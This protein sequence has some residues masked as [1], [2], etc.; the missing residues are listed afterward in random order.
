MMAMDVTDVL[1]ERP[2]EFLIEE[3]RFYLYPMT[4]GVSLLVGRCISTLSPDMAGFA[5]NPVAE[6]DR[7]VKERPDVA[8]RIL[9]YCTAKNREEV[10]DEESMSQR[11]EYFAE[12][13]SSSDQSLLL[14]MALTEDNVGA[15]MEHL[16]ITAEQQRRKN[17]L[18]AKKQDKNM[19]SFGGK[20][21]LG[22][23]IVPACEKLNLTP[24][25]VVWEIG[26]TFLQLLLADATSQ[27]YLS[28][29]ELKRAHGVRDDVVNAD[30]PASLE[31]IKSFKWD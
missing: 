12:K 19:L 11:Q 21:L 25:Q 24:R 29:E 13:L 26:Y 9:A 6:V 18:A 27:V 2:H 1:M 10:L 16:G 20:S 15:M 30:D 31:K 8:C 4:L 28:D 5:D 23:L 7:L 3:H 22:G 17:A 14:V